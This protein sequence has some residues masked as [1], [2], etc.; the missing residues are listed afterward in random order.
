VVPLIASD[1]YH[2]G[3]WKRREKRRFAKLFAGGA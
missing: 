2:R 1:V 3:P